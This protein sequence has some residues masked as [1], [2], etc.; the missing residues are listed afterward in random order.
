MA[1]DAFSEGIAIDIYQVRHYI[2][3]PKKT[4]QVLMCIVCFQK[5]LMKKKYQK[6]LYII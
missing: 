2:L 5:H 6:D 4:K 3:E 1:R